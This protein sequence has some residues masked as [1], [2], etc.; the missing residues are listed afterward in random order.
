MPPA[1]LEVQ[2]VA[3]AVAVAPSRASP[4][5]AVA[6]AV[7]PSRASLSEVAAQVEPLLSPQQA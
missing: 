6:V 1:T 5:V 3:V 7:V 4:L 2:E